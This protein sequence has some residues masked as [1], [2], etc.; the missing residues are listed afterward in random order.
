MKSIEKIKKH[1]DGTGSIVLQ[2]MMAKENVNQRNGDKNNIMTK[3]VI[4]GMLVCLCFMIYY[5]STKA[6]K[7]QKKAEKWETYGSWMITKDDLQ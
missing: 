5:S 4:S 1:S 2:M 6:N 3:I 7:R